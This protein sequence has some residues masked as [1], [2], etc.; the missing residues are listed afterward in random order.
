MKASKALGE[1]VFGVNH[2]VQRSRGWATRHLGRSTEAYNAAVDALCRFRD[3][4]LRIVALYI[5]GPS[6]H[7]PPHARAPIANCNVGP[8][9]HGA[10]DDLVRFLKEVW[11]LAT[12]RSGTASPKAAIDVATCRD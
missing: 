4:H 10:W 9:G 12:L 2:T 3:A 11:E 5:V 7:G 6:C 8:N 1:R